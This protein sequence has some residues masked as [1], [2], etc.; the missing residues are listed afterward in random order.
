MAVSNTLTGIQNVFTGAADDLIKGNSLTN[1]LFGGAGRD[2]VLGAG[3]KD[4]IIGGSGEGDD[5]YDGGTETDTVIYSSATQ[6]IIVNLT[7][8]Q[9]T[10][11]EIGTDQ[12]IALKTSSAAAGT[13]KSS[14]TPSPTSFPAARAMTSSTAGPAPTARCF[15]GCV[16]LMHSP[17]LGMA[18][19]V[20]LDLT[21]PIR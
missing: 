11:P 17:I 19:S 8:G 16:Q 14:A 10:G 21:A 12:L 3:G 7:T 13:I 6:G 1:W 18:V 4:F 20:W 2:E 15:P 9:A 5:Y